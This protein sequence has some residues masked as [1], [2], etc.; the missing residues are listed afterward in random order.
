MRL[1]GHSAV[2]SDLR[3]RLSSAQHDE[4]GVTHPQHFDIDE[5]RLTETLFEGAREMA[6]AELHDTGEVRN[7]EA[8]TDIRLNV[9]DHTPR[10]PGGEA[11]PRER[12]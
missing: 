10:L 12:G 9:G 4:L 8:E 2:K 6:N 1:V 11:T 3:K 5:G 7:A